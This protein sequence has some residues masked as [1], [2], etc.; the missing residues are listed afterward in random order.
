MASGSQAA[1]VASSCVVAV[2]RNR[3]TTYAEHYINAFAEERRR[4][5]RR[6]APVR[7]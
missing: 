3:T 7:L 2:C 5:A 4:Q 6:G 1:V